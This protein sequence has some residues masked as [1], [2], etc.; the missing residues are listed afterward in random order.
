MFEKLVNTFANCF[1]IP[2]LKSRIIFT[3]TLLGICRLIAWIPVPGLEVSALR[4]FL[5]STASMNIQILCTSNAIVGKRF[6]LSPWIRDSGQADKVTFSPTG[7]ILKS[8]MP[9]QTWNYRQYWADFHFKAVA[10]GNATFQLIRDG[11]LID[12]VTVPVSLPVSL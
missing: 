4:D 9:F 2:E 12:Q 11:E 6:S 5:N 3:L 1:K 10:S 7:L 8:L